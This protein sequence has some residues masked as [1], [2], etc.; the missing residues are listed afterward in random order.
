MFT[1]YWVG[2]N[3]KGNFG[4]VLTPKLLDYFNIPYNFQRDHKQ[5]Y[6]AICIGSILRHAKP[7][8]HVFGSG[9]MSRKNS[10]S[11]DA[12][13]HLV[14][15]PVTHQI[16]TDRGIDCP[17][18]F[19]DPALLLPLLQDESKKIHDVGIV[20]HESHYEQTLA[21]YPDYP[22]I[23]LR[24]Q[25]ALE[26]AKVITQ[27]RSIISGSLHGVIAAHAYGIPAAWVNFGA[28]KGDGIKF[29]DHYLS[30]GLEAVQSTVEEPIFTIGKF[31]MLPLIEVFK[32]ANTL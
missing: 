26:T 27:C 17:A 16:L 10:C 11:P 18:V 24:T 21:A 22:V 9:F 28:I 20:P 25:D 3:T 1:F 30:I 12:I 32:T 8:T 6:N 14:R 19:G 13:F 31:D 7:G 4:D 2:N 15:G 29:E 5:E 23:N